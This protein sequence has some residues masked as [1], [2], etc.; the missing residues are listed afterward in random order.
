[1]GYLILTAAVSVLVIIISGVLLQGKTPRTGDGEIAAT[2]NGVSIPRAG[3]ELAKRMILAASAITETLAYSDALD[4]YISA[5]LY[6]Q[7]LA[8]R[9]ASLTSVEID[10]RTQG[11]M[12]VGTTISVTGSVSLESARQQAGL[13]EAEF[14]TYMRDMSEL[15]ILR[16]RLSEELQSSADAPSATEVAGHVQS[17]A[18]LA[19]VGVMS[20]HYSTATEADAA[21]DE[22]TG[23]L[24]SYTPEDFVSEFASRKAAVEGLSEDATLTESYEFTAPT[25]LPDYAQAA[26]SHD[27][28]ELGVVKRADDS[29]V[30][31]L[32]IERQGT[33]K[34]DEYESRAIMD[35]RNR[36]LDTLQR[37]LMEQL[38]DEAVI[39]YE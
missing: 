21:L 28:G 5:E 27:P 37:T 22:L 14:G 26:I 19:Q 33:P 4:L 23:L 6:R 9:G 31:Y 15:Q 2:V 29:A 13:S 34:A 36:N 38:W 8:R 16:Q 30:L 12:D 17:S 32:V 25:E 20:I 35:L 11:Y 39:V 24:A 10:K 3:V 7:E 18:E 1:M